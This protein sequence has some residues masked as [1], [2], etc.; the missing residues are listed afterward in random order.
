VIHSRRQCDSVD[1]V[2]RLVVAELERRWN[3]ALATEAQ[4]EAE[5]MSLQQSHQRPL[6]DAQKGE[7]F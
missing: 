6:S 2:N 7:L 3:Q 1:P 5:L 4:L